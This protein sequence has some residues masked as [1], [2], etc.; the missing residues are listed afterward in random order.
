M[1]IFAHGTASGLICPYLELISPDGRLRPNY[2]IHGTVTG[3]MSCEKPNLQQIPRASDKEWNGELKQAFIP[4]YG[5]SLYEADYSQLELR[6]AAA[7]AKEEGLLQAFAEGRDVFTEMSNQLGMARHDAKTM[8]YTIQYGGG[9]NRLSQVF[10]ISSERAGEL[11]SNFYQT[12]PGFRAKTEAA[13]RKAKSVGVLKYWSGRKRHFVDREAEAHKAFNSVIQGG[14]AE[15]M[16]HTMIRLFEEVDNNDCQM[17]LQV[18]DSIIF[19]IRTELLST[20]VP[21]IKSVME[22]VIPDFGV[23]FTCEINEWGK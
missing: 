11:R 12:Y 19:E 3:R 8:T 14:A 18:H 20:Y 1:L 2:K 15:I 4:K 22:A 21:L 17:L 9:I 6:L 13:S 7:Y 10:K 16:K 5:Y 23:I